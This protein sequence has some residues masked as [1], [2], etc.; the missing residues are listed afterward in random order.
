MKWL[1]ATETQL[2]RDFVTRVCL[3]AVMARIKEYDEQNGHSVAGI[4]TKR[5]LAAQ[6][7]CRDWGMANGGEQPACMANFPA[8]YLD[9]FSR[10]EQTVP[11]NKTW[12][13]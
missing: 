2:G 7:K 3:I 11:F 4:S 10:R 1:Q 5:M 13:V 6:E 8:V 12:N 9:R